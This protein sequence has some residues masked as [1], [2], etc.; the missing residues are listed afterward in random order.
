[1]QNSKAS[2]MSDEELMDELKR[3]A[4]QWFNNEKILLLE[5]LFRRYKKCQRLAS[6]NPTLTSSSS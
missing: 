4:A 3:L 2:L 5:E 1:M 6:T